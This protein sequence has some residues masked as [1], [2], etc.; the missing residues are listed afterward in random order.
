MRSSLACPPARVTALMIALVA[1][2][3]A[4]CETTEA[5]AQA[6]GPAPPAPAEP[7]EAPHP[8]AGL[9]RPPM[10][11]LQLFSWREGTAW[12]FALVVGTNR[13]MFPT[14]SEVARDPLVA[15]VDGLLAL[16]AK[17][18]EG[19]EIHWANLTVADPED[20]GGH[21]ELVYPDD[22]TIREIEARARAAGHQLTR[23]R[24]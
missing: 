11:G 19:T 14:R 13:A 3:L 10:K 21:P 17:L 16:L 23:H 1:A 24:W 15:G 18:P 8:L 5:R 6:S 9:D 7:E 12:R 2:L 4:A 20:T 22:A